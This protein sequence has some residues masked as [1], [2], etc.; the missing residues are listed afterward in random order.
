MV[1][2]PPDQDELA[3]FG[4]RADDF[5]AVEVWPDVW[6]AVEAFSALGTQWRVSANGPVGLD[7]AAIPVVFRMLGVRREDWQDLFD[8]LRLIERAALEEMHKE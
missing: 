4:L 6:P 5:G 3:R 7:Y 8:D 2:K 1:R